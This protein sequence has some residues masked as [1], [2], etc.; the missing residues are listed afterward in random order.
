MDLNIEELCNS[1][2]NYQTN[3]MFTE[4]IANYFL[5]LYELMEDT[6]R[7]ESILVFEHAIST[8]FRSIKREIPE[9]LRRVVEPELEKIVKEFFINI[10]SR[11]DL[12]NKVWEML[13]EVASD[14]YI[15]YFA[16]YVK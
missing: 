14:I 8:R 6:K 2:I 4:V 7:R 12:S 11:S 1:I 10:F 16:E 3:D 9:K 15:D 13:I 5:E